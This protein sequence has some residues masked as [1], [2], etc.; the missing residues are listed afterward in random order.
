VTTMTEQLSDSNAS[1][2]TGAEHQKR[3]PN[4]PYAISSFD[5]PEKVCLDLFC[6]LGGF[7]AAFADADEWTVVT[8]DIEDRFDPDIQADVLDLRPS[9][10]LHLI[11]DAD[12]LVVLASPPCTAFSKAA[13]GTHIDS[14]GRPVSEWG[15]ESLALT[16]HTRGLIQGL[17][18]EWYF[19]E[20]P[21]GGMRN[22][23]GDDPAAPVWLCQYG[24]PAA[25]PTDLWGRI[26][27]SFD[28]RTCHNGNDE[29]HHEP[30]PRGS[31]GGV[32]GMGTS[33]ERAELPY[34]LSAEILE[35]VENPEPEQQKLTEA[36][37]GEPAARQEDDE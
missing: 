11:D 34:G 6:G 37:T 28:A 7:S 13:S 8:V 32:Q 10:L 35:A 2:N 4:K 9:N 3:N 17:D 1:A 20:N 19:I 14:D 27:P 18:P 21:Q 12:V 22:V 23:L 29:C 24:H 26:P 5:A 30:A 36:L 25:K 33:A 15:A 16:H 31:S